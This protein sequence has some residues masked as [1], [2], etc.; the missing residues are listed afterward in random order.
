M[1]KKKKKTQPSGTIWH[2]PVCYSSCLT[3]GSQAV[4]P[5]TLGVHRDLWTA[6]CFQGQDK[7]Y[8]EDCQLLGHRDL[9]F[10]YQNYTTLLLMILLSLQNGI[11]NSYKTTSKYLM[12]KIWKLARNRN[13]SNVFSQI[14]SFEISMQH[15]PNRESQSIQGQRSSRDCSSGQL[16]TGPAWDLCYER[17]PTPDMLMI[18]CYTYR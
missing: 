4:V 5:G 13:R 2:W 14:S 7:T 18:F 11:L 10:L 16:M 8:V 12:C 1:Q 3:A 6:S 17:E 9:Q 15:M